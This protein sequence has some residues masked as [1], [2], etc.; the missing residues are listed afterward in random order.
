V[1]T[2]I[3]GSQHDFSFGEV[4]V[5]LKRVDD[6][7]ARKGGLRQMVNARILNS[8]SVQNR[9]GR[10]ALFPA[11]NTSRIEEVTM[12]PG[13]VFKIAFG[14]SIAFGEI[15][16][17]NSSGAQVAY[18]PTQGNGKLLPWTRA[19]ISQIVF[20]QINL[21]IYITFGFGMRPQV[22][23]WDGVSTWSIADY[24]E[25]Q[26][27]NQKR[28][29]FYRISPQGISI[30]PAATTGSV[31][32]S[33]S[34]PVFAAG[35]VGTRIRFVNSQILITAFTDSQHVTGT[36]EQ[37]LPGSQVLGFASDPRAVFSVGD[38][39]VGSVSGSK[40]IITTT[41]VSSITVQLL[42]TS[43][44]IYTSI[45]GSQNTVA[46]VGT[47]IIVGP[48]GSLA[49]N[50]ANSIGNPTGCTVWDDE[51]MNDYRG[52]PASVFTDQFRL[53]FCNYP[54]VPNGIGWS[55]INSPN[56]MY[57]GAN[58]S[59]A[60]FELAPRKV[61]VYFVV[62]GPEG[63]EFVFCDRAL[64]YIPI[65]ATNPLKP[66]SVAFQLLSGDGC[67]QV[68]P[69]LA[70]EAILYV[71]AGQNSMMAVIAT[72]AFTRPYNTKNLSDFHA[73]LFTSIVAIAAPSAD[74]T[75]N[76][77]YAYVLNADGSLIV[78]KYDP[79]SLQGSKPVI[80]W[81]S[82]SGGGT[83]S[84]V[85]TFAADVIFT[86]SYFGAS[87]CEILDDAQ[88]LDCALAVNAPPAPFA[89]PVGKG[90]LWFIPSQSV[91]LIDQVTR[92]MG[93]YQVD[94]NGFIV[95]QNNGGEDLTIA[96]LVAGQP[97]TLMVEPFA[98]DAQSGADMGQRMKLRQISNVAVYVINS[99]GF[100]INALFSSKQTRTSPA[101]GTVMQ[102]RRFDTW[103]QDDDPTKPPPQ[104]ETVETWAPPGSSYDPRVMIM[105]DTPG[106]FLIA[107]V[108]MEVSL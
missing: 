107:E 59:D 12:S 6:H 43:S 57:V 85:S 46:F 22:L 25:L 52:Y 16:I 102:S 44:S 48:S 104:R 35:V 38:V 53:G 1:A 50:A 7:P 14:A 77:R 27:G 56:D 3:Q 32:I 98:P 39:V 10:R 70:Q 18:F 100:V 11:T 72:G 20:A 26:Q 90:P 24:T 36:V 76:E 29:P 66:G 23:T 88:Y 60:M 106:P 103:N 93:T 58:P 67:A 87:I 74:G 97:W 73:H 5:A 28:T 42:T 4:D 34:A 41:A 94:A 19:T 64:Y 86:S 13:N 49:T 75:F 62:A 68:Q 37:T 79:D 31:A 83:L 91:S 54:S 84:W 105:K 81:G 61:Q 65:S 33:A 45:S 40:G 99:T 89:A 51:V 101:L 78:G 96:S 2:K 47:D 71:N 8:G 55:S 80:G 17:F 92:A 69:R 82:W 95:P 15:R 108:G 30:T 63:S 21:S 9:P